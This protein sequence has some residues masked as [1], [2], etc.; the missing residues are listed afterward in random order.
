[1]FTYPIDKS[2][3]KR[4]LHIHISTYLTVTETLSFVLIHLSFEPA[5]K[6]SIYFHAFHLITFSHSV[7]NPHFHISAEYSSLFT[8]W[9]AFSKSMHVQNAFFHISRSFLNDPLKIFLKKRLVYLLPS[10]KLSLYFPNF[11]QS[12]TYPFSQNYVQ[13]FIDIL[14]QTS[15]SFLSP[16]L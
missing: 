13:T 12:P 10:I 7:T 3:Q 4:P 9:Y 8:L 16:S 2:D 14:N 1:M 5:A 6:H 11:P 15:Y